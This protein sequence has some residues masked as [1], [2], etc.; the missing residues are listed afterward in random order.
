MQHTSPAYSPSV[1]HHSDASMLKFCILLHQH[2][3]THPSLHLVETINSTHMLLR[4]SELFCSIHRKHTTHQR[5]KDGMGSCAIPLLAGAHIHTVLTGKVNAGGQTPPCKL[6]STQPHTSWP[7]SCEHKPRP[8]STQTCTPR[9]KAHSTM[10]QH[11]DTCLL[12]HNQP[13]SQPS[14]NPHMLP[15]KTDTI[16]KVDM[17][18][19]VSAKQMSQ[20]GHQRWQRSIS[21]QWELAGHPVGRGRLQLAGLPIFT[22]PGILAICVG[23]SKNRSPAKEQTHSP[24]R[25]KHPPS[26]SYRKRPRLK[27]QPTSQDK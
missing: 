27:M 20:S 13:H 21:R 15:E 23:P 8:G 1:H 26:H 14:Q 5:E 6:A 2:R 7:T 22:P 11:D 19:Q 9:C 24:L 10:Q 16:L 12:M 17:L 18:T 25:I 3:L 4:N